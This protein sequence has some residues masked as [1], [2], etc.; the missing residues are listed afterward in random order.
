MIFVNH[1]IIIS[2]ESS[3]KHASLLTAVLP[4]HVPDG[5]LRIDT[6]A[7]AVL[8]IARRGTAIGDNQYSTSFGKEILLF[9]DCCTQSK[10]ETCFHATE[11]RGRVMTSV[12]SDFDDQM[13]FL[14]ARVFLYN[15]SLSIDKQHSLQTPY[16]STRGLSQFCLAHC[17]IYLLTRT[18]FLSAIYLLKR[19]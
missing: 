10:T 8:H 15:S 12:S 11:M 3:S 1:C 5:V 19:W 2:N 16:F 7:A 17:S 6:C 14:S 13:R 9:D 18:E 4:R